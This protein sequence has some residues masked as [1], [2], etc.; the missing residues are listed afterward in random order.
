MLRTNMADLPESHRDGLA[1][2]RRVAREF[3]GSLHEYGLCC[4]KRYSA[5]QRT[6]GE[7]QR[8]PG[9]YWRNVIRFRVWCGDQCAF[10]AYD[11]T[12][13]Y[14]RMNDGRVVAEK[15]QEKIGAIEDAEGNRARFTVVVFASSDGLAKAPEVCFKGVEP[16]RMRDLELDKVPPGVSLRFSKSGSYDEPSTVATVG[17]NFPRKRPREFSANRGEG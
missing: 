16:R 13:F 2:L 10:D 7:L 5:R 11:H 14:R 1:D 3:D 17:E 8:R 15:G 12:P 4:R 6:E 9:R